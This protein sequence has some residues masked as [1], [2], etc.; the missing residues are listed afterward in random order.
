DSAHFPDRPGL[1]RAGNPDVV[2]DEGR[3]TRLGI[4]RVAVPT[5]DGPADPDR[6]DVAC[7]GAG[8]TEQVVRGAAG[9]TAP[10]AAVPVQNE[11]GP[12]GDPYIVRAAAPDADQLIVRPAAR[13]LP[14]A[15]L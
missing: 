3:P 11:I 6:P 9:H 12:A 4:P 8:D 7:V 1:V 10:G 5:H 13:D 2:E 14:A 15:G